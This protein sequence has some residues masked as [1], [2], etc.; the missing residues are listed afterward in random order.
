MEEGNSLTY[1]GYSVDIAQLSNFVVIKKGEQWKQAGLILVSDL[2]KG[3][4]DFRI[5]WK[6]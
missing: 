3:A 6:M 1:F 2:G 4:S 5:F